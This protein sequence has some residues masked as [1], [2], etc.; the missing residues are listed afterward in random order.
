M[1]RIDQHPVPLP[2]H[3]GPTALGLRLDRERSDRIERYAGSMRGRSMEAV[4]ADVFCESEKSEKDVEFSLIDVKVFGSMEKIVR[5]TF[6]K[7]H[8]WTQRLYVNDVFTNH[9][10]RT[11]WRQAFRDAFGKEGQD[12]LLKLE[13]S[14]KYKMA[15]TVG[16]TTLLDALVHIF[17]ESDEV[18]DSDL[19]R[20]IEHM[21]N[22]QKHRELY[23]EYSEASLDKKKRINAEFGRCFAAALQLLVDEA[24]RRRPLAAK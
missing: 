16:L 18:E 24:E 6:E 21:W 11:E 9:G 7:Y 1:V 3:R 13:K 10:N 8:D 19:A 12:L 4:L 22:P 5:C 15:P 14:D 23:E 17:S 20:N 2:E